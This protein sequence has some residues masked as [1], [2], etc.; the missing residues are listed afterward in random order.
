MCIATQTMAN[1]TRPHHLALPLE[2][3]VLVEV[4]G[5]GCTGPA[6]R[7]YVSH[8]VAYGNVA[9]ATATDIAIA[10]AIAIDIAV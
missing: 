4:E 2:S 8:S 1:A 3:L 7:W 5:R 9:I 6:M 10:I